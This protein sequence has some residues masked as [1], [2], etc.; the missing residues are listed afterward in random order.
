MIKL[1]KTVQKQFV[2]SLEIDHLFK[3]IYLA[4]IRTFQVCGILPEASLNSPPSSMMG[5][6]YQRKTGHKHQQPHF[7]RW[8][9]WFLVKYE[10]PM[11]RGA[12]KN[13]HDPTSK[14]QGKP[15]NKLVIEKIGL[16]EEWNNP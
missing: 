2:L 10:K 12:V 15:S 11:A 3:K 6:F 1:D 16:S 14:Q 9:S 7:G 5:S 8:M 13:Y 4:S